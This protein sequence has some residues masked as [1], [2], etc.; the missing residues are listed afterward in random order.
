MTPA[1]RPLSPARKTTSTGAVAFSSEYEDWTM[2][3]DRMAQAA[4]PKVLAFGPFRLFLR[5]RLLTS[6]GKPVHIGSRAFD[7]LVAL[8]ERPGELVSKR[9]LIARVWPS[10]IVEQA[11]LAVQIAGLRRALGDGRRGNRYVVNIPG[12]GYRFVA[13]VAV[14]RNTSTEPAPRRPRLDNLPA[15]STRPIAGSDGDDASE[16]ALQRRLL[17]ILRSGGVGNTKAAL[18]FM[19]SLLETQDERV[20]ILDVP[21]SGKQ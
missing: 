21:P 20:F 3:I 16:Q 9:E 12:R 15:R 13:P 11:N 7:I 2:A 18:A 8:L 17:A 10:T 1:Q 5:E 4:A 19:E 14:E 6:Y